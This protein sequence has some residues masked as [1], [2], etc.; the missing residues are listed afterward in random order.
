MRDLLVEQFHYPIESILILAG[1]SAWGLIGFY[2]SGHG[3]RQR[4][5]NGDEVDGFDETICPADFQTN[6]MIFD[7]DINEPIVRP[8]IPGVTLHAIFDSCHSGTVLDLP[9]AYNISTI[10]QV[11][12]ISSRNILTP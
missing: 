7:D 9:Y 2:F 8:L 6:G 1:R 12:F 4:D 5:L 11:L 3:L 10:L